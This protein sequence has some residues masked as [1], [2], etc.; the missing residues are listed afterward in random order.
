VLSP[1]DSAGTAVRSPPRDPPTVGA[2]VGDGSRYNAR[3]TPSVVSGGLSFTTLVTGTFHTCGLTSGGAAYCWGDDHWGELGD[4]S[5]TCE[6]CESSIPVAVYGGLSFR[7]LAGGG[8]YT[9]GLANDGPAYCW[10]LNDSGQLG[11]G[12]RTNRSAPALVA[13]T[14]LNP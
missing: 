12:S 1:P 10:G 11:D 14:G 5:N 4:S 3:P 6:T 9:C 13:G 2:K 7:I 8:G